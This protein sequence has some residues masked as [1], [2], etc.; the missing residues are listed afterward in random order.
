MQDPECNHEQ[1][2]INQALLAEALE[3]GEYGEQPQSDEY[4]QPLRD[5]QGRYTITGV[6][7][8]MFTQAVWIRGENG[9]SV[10]HGDEISHA[11]EYGYTHRGEDP[12]E[13]QLDILLHHVGEGTSRGCPEQTACA[14]DLPQDQER[15]E[16]TPHILVNHQILSQGKLELA[17]IR[18]DRR[19]DLPLD[20][21]SFEVAAKLLRESPGLLGERTCDQED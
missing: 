9:W 17:G 16:H 14:L 5:P 19:T 21:L 10:Y 11:R 12:G 15:S 7:T 18:A 4:A 13:E 6:A 8:S 2:K 3:S 1:Q 20:W